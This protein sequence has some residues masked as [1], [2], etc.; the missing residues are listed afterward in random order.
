MRGRG[1]IASAMG[2]G[3]L[4]LLA[5]GCG[6]A[7]G[8]KAKPG[9]SP[10]V[11]PAKPLPMESAARTGTWTGS[12]HKAHPLRLKPTRLAAGHPSDLAHIRLDDNLKGLVP[13]YL[14]VSYTNTGKGTVSELYP[15]RNF[16][17]NGVDGQAGEQLSLFRTNPLATGNGLP[18]ECQE[19]GKATLAA[20]ETSAVCQIFMLPKGL[21]PG[22]VSY[23]DDG[24]GTLL[25]QIG[26]AQQGAAGVLPPHQPADV[27]TTD[28]DRR[29]AT[30]LATPKNIRTGSLDDLSRFDLRAEEKQ[31]VPY[32]VTVVYRNTG[33][34]DLLPSLND[35]LTLTGVSGRQAQKMTL[36]DIGG[37]GVPQCPESV[38]HKMLKPGATVTECTIHMLPK[39]D[40]PASLTFEGSGDGA[41]PVSWRAT[42]DDGK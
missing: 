8:A 36:L 30:A 29:T 21:K 5:V 28:S 14:T 7:S 11:V 31:L 6:G 20:G 26:G 27:V 32:Y 25:W 13:Y 1:R 23:K 18:P 15:E 16:S 4:M 39:G 17:V 24:G 2:A 41:R 9:A 40:P 42:A 3:A 33:R 35:S 19:S 38:P 12:D 22:N 10:A 37:P 34:Y